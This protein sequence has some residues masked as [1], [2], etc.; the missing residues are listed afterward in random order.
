MVLLHLN[1]LK[2]FESL[3]WQVL[4]RHAKKTNF[5]DDAARQCWMLEMIMQN[6]RN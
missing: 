5:H 1:G 6:D 2:S 3:N 4:K